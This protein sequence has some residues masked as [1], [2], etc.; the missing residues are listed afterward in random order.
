VTVD[1]Q[2]KRLLLHTDAPGCAASIFG[3]VASPCRR[4]FDNSPRKRHRPNPSQPRQNAAAARAVV[5][6]LPNDWLLA[7]EPAPPNSARSA[8]NVAP[9][10]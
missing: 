3:A 10:G 4:S 2:E 5:P 1:Q 6:R 7:I 9:G 8:D